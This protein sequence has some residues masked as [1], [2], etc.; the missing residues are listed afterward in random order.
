MR[1]SS[2]RFGRWTVALSPVAL[3]GIAGIVLGGGLAPAGCTSRGQA[4]NTGDEADDTEP[5]RRTTELPEPGPALTEDL[6]L[7]LA[8]AKNYHH[9]ADVYLQEARVEQAIATVELILGIRFPAGSPE[10]EDVQLDARARLAK[11]LV[12]QGKLDEAMKTVDD[13]IAGAR[14]Q[15]FFLANLHTVRG[16]V[17][18]ARAAAADDDDDKAAARTARRDAIEAYD[19]AIAIGKALL[20]KLAKEESP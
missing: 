18:E 14:R 3:A 13:G 17:F 1:I 15:S 4:E 8:L 19:R 9:K 5:E 20:D 12:T 10:G 7:G 2:H 11:L 16:E 6:M